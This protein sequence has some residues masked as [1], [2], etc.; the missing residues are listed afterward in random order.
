M[1]M[2]MVVADQ[3]GAIAMSDT[4]NAGTGL[5][6]SGL[7]PS[8]HRAAHIL[9]RL[10]ARIGRALCAKDYVPT[11]LNSK[12]LADIGETTSEA[13]PD[14]FDPPLGLVGGQYKVDGL[15]LFA[16]PSSRLG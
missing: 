16:H 14:L 7:R 15:P 13:P 2:C 3:N 4:L 9:G 12:L 1:G 11:N 10:G 6:S 5:S 8:P